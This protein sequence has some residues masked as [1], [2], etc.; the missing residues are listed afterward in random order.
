MEATRVTFSK[1][2][3]RSKTEAEKDVEYEK[4]RQLLSFEDVS[5]YFVVN[6]SEFMKMKNFT[7]FRRQNIYNLIRSLG[8][9]IGPTCQLK[10]V[11]KVCFGG[12]MRL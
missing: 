5:I 8:M 12:L 3:K 2:E 10:C 1:P 11:S 9:V 7:N 4:S 6:G